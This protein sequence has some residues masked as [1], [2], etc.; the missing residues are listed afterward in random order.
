MHAASAC[1]SLCMGASWTCSRA[2]A[3]ARRIIR[4]RLRHVLSVGVTEG[5]PANRRVQA[6][7]YLRDLQREHGLTGEPKASGRWTLTAHHMCHAA[8]AVVLWKLPAADTAARPLPLSCLQTR[9]CS[10]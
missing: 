6:W 8:A 3:G 4:W 10:T 2:I 1:A 7:V 9:R 5:H